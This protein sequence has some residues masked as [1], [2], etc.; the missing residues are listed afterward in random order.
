MA[1]GEQLLG[2]I[3]K[4]LDVSRIESVGVQLNR[5]P[6]TSATWCTGRHVSG[7]T[8]QA[9]SAAGADQLPEQLPRIFR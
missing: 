4:L 5:R 9:P 8:C 3:S 7:P 6:L 2:L 1:K